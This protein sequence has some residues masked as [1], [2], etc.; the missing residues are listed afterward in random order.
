MTSNRFAPRLVQ[1]YPSSPHTYKKGASRSFARFL[2]LLAGLFVAC[3]SGFAVP[4]SWPADT[5]GTQIP[6]GNQNPAP[7]KFESSGAV[8]N[9]P[10]SKL[11][12]VDDEGW[13][14]SMASSGAGP[15]YVNVQANLDM[16]AI[17]TTG[18]GSFLYAGI[19][20]ASSKNPPSSPQIRELNASTMTLSGKTWWLTMPADSSQGMEGLTWIK[21]G[22]HPYANSA[23]GGLFYASSQRNGTIYVFDVNLAQGSNTPLS[24]IGSFTPDATQT[25]ISDLYF[26][27]AQRILYVLYDTAN[28]MIEIDTSTQAYEPIATY[29]LPT[30]PTDQEGVTL[31][32]NCSSASTTIYLA[33]DASNQGVY[34]FSGYPEWCASLPLL[35]GDATINSSNPATNYGTAT[36]LTADTSSQVRNFLIRFAAPSNAAQV[37]RARLVFYVTDGT[38]SSPNFCSTATGWQASTVTWNNAPACTGGQSGGGRVVPANAWASYDVT[39]AYQTS[40]S[41]RFI[42]TSSDDFVASS[43]EASSHDP[44]LLVWIHKTP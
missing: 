15:S 36:T 20:Y 9:P 10:T 34:S 6:L 21:N 38:G 25:D 2:A 39:T 4:L 41:F 3:Q 28:R 8:W 26:D 22:A 35:G 14:A 33:S 37:A 44:Y 40:P 17:A 7:A 12:V 11:Y 42:G 1:P 29:N 23:S 30:T 13:I 16:E 24:P 43:S 31:R 19:E 27:P 32:P 18:T 5:P